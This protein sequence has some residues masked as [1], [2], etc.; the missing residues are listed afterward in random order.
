VPSGSL[1]AGKWT[2]VI[3]GWGW[4]SVQYAV[5]TGAPGGQYRVYPVYSSGPLPA[6]ITHQVRVYGDI[7]L[8]SPIDTQWGADPIGP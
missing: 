1:P 5:R 3:W 7:W 4:Y 2:K 8:F 6:Q